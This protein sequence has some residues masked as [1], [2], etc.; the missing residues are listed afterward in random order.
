MSKQ[1]FQL[2]F[3]VSQQS[4]FLSV[5]RNTSW[6]LLTQ[7]LKVKETGLMKSRCGS[8]PAFEPWEHF[9]PKTLYVVPFSEVLKLLSGRHAGPWS[10]WSTSRMSTAVRLWL[11][12]QL[13]LTLSGEAW[14]YILW[15]LL[16]YSNI[17]LH[18]LNLARGSLFLSNM[19]EI[20]S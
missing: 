18:K 7:D 5:I 10:H 17:L 13:F 16:L 9:L 1:I 6:S 19:R 20:L 4:S 3:V 14:V 15:F 11:N 8:L 2:Q 12:N